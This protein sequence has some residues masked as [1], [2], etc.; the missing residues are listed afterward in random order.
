MI[1]Q[2]PTIF[3]GSLRDNVDPSKS[4]SDEEVLNAIKS[5]CL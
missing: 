4:H 1:M 2:D 3:E 5:C